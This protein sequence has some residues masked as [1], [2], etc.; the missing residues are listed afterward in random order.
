MDRNLFL[1][2]ALSFAVLMLWTLVIEPPPS[3]RA[4]SPEATAPAAEPPD[5][6]EIP[7]P[8]PPAE[9]ALPALQAAEAQPAEASPKPPTTTPQGRRIA[10]ETEL[11]QAELDTLGAGIAHWQLKHYHTSRRE[12][13]QPLEL[14]TGR[15]PFDRAWVTPFEELGLGDLSQAVFELEARDGLRFSFRHV[16]D[17]VSVT[18]EF[19]FHE[20]SYAFE[21]RV[22]V[23]NQ[24]QQVIEPRFALTWPAS[25]RS[26]NDFR[27]QSLAAL[28]AGS[29]AVEQ[30]ERFGK[31][32][33]LGRAPQTEKRFE[34]EVDWAGFQT[35]YFVG[36]MLP[37]NPSQ[38]GGRFVATQPGESGVAQVYF[39]PVALRP[40]QQAERLFRG[41]VG[42]KEPDRLESV[43]GGLS[44]SIDLGWAW[45][46]PLTR[47]FNWLLAALHSVV[48]NY[49]LAII[50]LT[51]LVRLVTAPLTNKQMRSM[52]RMRAISPKLKELREKYG[53][54]RQKQSEEMMRLYR[55]EGV[56]PLGGCFPMLLQL[57]VFIGLF[58]ALRSSIQLRQAPFV[59]WIDD[60]SAPDTLFEI[61]GI[62][63]PFRVLPL[64]MGVTMLLQQRITPAQ[65]MDPS[66]QKMM[67]TMMP[68]VMTVVFYQFPSGLVL[69]WM[70][71]NV[72]A[73]AH[74]LWIGRGLRSQQA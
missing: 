53:D 61:P 38:A 43:G 67:M 59:G 7:P 66:Q 51:V 50:I 16:R 70:V 74:Q 64:V 6:Q 42:P 28:H 11:F 32:G 8:A 34:S 62:G 49:G 68:I 69:Y 73:I 54:D 58:Y 10:F 41:Y 29:L 48:P 39:D 27:Q 19:R 13:G 71:S 60:L 18:K 24:S 31:P 72:L 40:G 56:N 37:D 57:P 33:F 2:F 14:T 21:L 5:E 45:I 4:A 52:E 12:G 15:A 1:A 55:Q 25:L 23:E 65:G 26:G 35:T 20:D 22:S 46:V 30:L 17:H 36:A 47:F 63:I 44:R 3:R 9:G